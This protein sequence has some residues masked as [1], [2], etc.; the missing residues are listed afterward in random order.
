MYFIFIIFFIFLISCTMF[1]ITTPSNSQ[2]IPKVIYQT[3]KALTPSDLV[4]EARN[5]HNSWIKANP[6]YTIV[7]M[8]DQE[9]D[10]FI[11]THFDHQVY[12]VFN[13]LPLGVMKA[14]FFRYA[15][16]YINGGIYTDIDTKCMKRI[17]WIPPDADAIIGKEN[18]THFCQ[19]T[20]AFS[21]KHPL[22]KKVIDNIVY[23]ISQNGIDTRD[24]HFVHKTTGPEIWTKSIQAY[25]IETY[26]DIT[27]QKNPTSA[28]LYDAY[29]H[30]DPHFIIYDNDTFNK[31]AVLHMFGSQNFSSGYDHWIK[32]R[33][34]IQQDIIYVN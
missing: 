16:I 9:I 31:T 19:W 3:H 21:P 23:Q 27:T 10:D 4:P 12:K 17:N 34:N 28:H 13:A 18:D 7:Y 2:K 20:F 8:N 29:K 32:L 14:D 5:A 15:I 25:L 11:K 33:D 30:V 24:E 26:G 22:L 1:P 6:D